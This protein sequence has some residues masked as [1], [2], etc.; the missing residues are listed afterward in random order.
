MTQAPPDRR[1]IYVER[2]LDASV[3]TQR[4]EAA[5]DYA[6][7]VA[8]DGRTPQVNDTHLISEGRPAA[9]VDATYV[10]FNESMM[11]PVLPPPTASSNIAQ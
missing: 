10:R 9:A 4:V 5:R 7:R 8:T 3:T 1:S 2:S 6:M 11:P